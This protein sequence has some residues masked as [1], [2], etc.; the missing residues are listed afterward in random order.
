ML[1]W[2]QNVWRAPWNHLEFPRNWVF[3]CT[4]H[5]QNCTKARDNHFD[6]RAKP[7][8]IHSIKLFWTLTPISVTILQKPCKN[9]S[10]IIQKSFKNHSKTIQKPNGKKGFRNQRTRDSSW[11]CYRSY[12]IEKQKRNVVTR[13]FYVGIK[14]LRMISPK[15]PFHLATL[16]I[17]YCSGC[18]D[19]RMF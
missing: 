7:F 8:H 12:R 2:L 3:N 9:H 15:D 1:V 10:K 13:A 18:T 17:Q 5:P 19:E 6:R 14:S 16:C 4:F 11:I